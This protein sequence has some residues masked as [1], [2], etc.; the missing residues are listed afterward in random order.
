MMKYL[1]RRLC[2]VATVVGLIS[3]T[4]GSTRSVTVLSHSE[5]ILAY[6][7]NYGKRTRC[8]K[9]IGACQHYDLSRDILKNEVP[10]LSARCY[11]E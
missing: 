1:I 8:M 11:R 4:C 10:V 2:S 9:L 7:A 6:N 5:T 3:G